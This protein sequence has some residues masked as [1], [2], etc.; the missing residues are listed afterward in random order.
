MHI[1]R[2]KGRRDL[3]FARTGPCASIPKIPMKCEL[4]GAVLGMDA[5][6]VSSPPLLAVISRRARPAG[7]EDPAA[8]YVVAYD[9]AQD[10]TEILPV[11]WS[12]VSTLAP[13]E[14]ARLIDAIGAA[15]EKGP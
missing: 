14:M 15:Q 3:F 5:I 13:E 2:S 8:L 7:M 12:A 1:E 9:I 11:A 4:S 10:K 6:V